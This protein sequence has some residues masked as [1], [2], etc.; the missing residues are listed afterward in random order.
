M[1][2]S[3]IQSTKTDR[4]FKCQS[5]RHYRNPPPSHLLKRKR[6]VQRDVLPSKYPT[7]G[8]RVRP[9]V[10]SN[11]GKGATISLS[12][13]TSPR[14]ARELTRRMKEETEPEA[15]PVTPA[16]L[17]GSALILN[18][19]APLRAFHRPAA[20]REWRNRAEHRRSPLPSAL[21]PETEG[22]WRSQTFFFF[23]SIGTL[24]HQSAALRQ[25]LCGSRDQPTF[26]PRSFLSAVAHVVR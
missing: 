23:L 7:T 24:S 15:A 25:P 9:H 13:P 22:H 26:P 5:L 14:E 11:A 4:I 3:P 18:P 17:V 2:C 16:S 12:P 20:D 8:R 19:W 1:S 21:F 6:A 10:S